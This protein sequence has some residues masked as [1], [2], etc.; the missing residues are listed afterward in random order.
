MTM[1]V[2]RSVTILLGFFKAV[3]WILL[4]LI[5]VVLGMNLLH[6]TGTMDISGLRD[7][8]KGWS[9]A[10]SDVLFVA[11]ED[12]ADEVAGQAEDSSADADDAASTNTQTDATQPDGAQADAADRAVRSGSGSSGGLR[13]VPWAGHH[14]A[15]LWRPVF[16]ILR[17]GA[18]VAPE[19]LKAGKRHGRGKKARGTARS[20]R[21]RVRSRAGTARSRRARVRS[22]AGDNA[23]PP[24]KAKLKSGDNAQPPRKG[25]LKSGGNAQTAA[26]GC[27]Q[28]RGQRETAAQGYA[29]ER[30]QRA[31]AAQG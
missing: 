13:S 15:Q 30:G 20:R 8:V 19:C 18:P 5:V 1:S 12:S 26:R 14:S 7:T 16:F 24:R 22:R 21:A 17:F 27:A 4:I 25:A 29:Q 10:L 9:P 31:A 3:F 28:K 2:I 6:K 11:V 23:Q